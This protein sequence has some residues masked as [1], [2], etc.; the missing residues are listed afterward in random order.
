[1]IAERRASDAARRRNCSPRHVRI[2]TL[3]ATVDEFPSSQLWADEV[4]RVLAYTAAAGQFERY[5]GA[6]R[7]RKSQFESALLELRVAF[8]LHKEPI[9]NR[10]VGVCGEGSK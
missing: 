10:G 9:Q 7:G 5:L 6:L 8:F 1:M 4:E 3:T 2:G